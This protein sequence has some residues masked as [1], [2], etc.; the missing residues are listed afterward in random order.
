MAGSPKP[1]SRLPAALAGV[2]LALA[3]VGIGYLAL[4]DSKAPPPRPMVG[5]GGS[6]QMGPAPVRPDPPST[7]EIPVQFS[8]RIPT[9]PKPVRPV[10]DEGT[11]V[12]ARAVSPQRLRSVEDN[13]VERLGQVAEQRDP[14]A[15][16][17]LGLM[18]AKGTG[19]GRD[20]TEAV[21]WFRRAAE[22][23]NA[24]AQ[25]WLGFMY[26]TGRGVG[27]DD[28]EAVRWYRRAIKKGNA[29]AQDNLGRMYETGRGVG[30]DLVEAV[31]WY[32]MAA[33]QGYELAKKNLD[34]LRKSPRP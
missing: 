9:Q 13:R 4:Q 18:Y 1:H 14:A 10:P 15:E 26:Q 11:T 23:G 31:R 30:R 5:R 25:T 22:E 34:R 20:D 3:M 27:Q 7:S 33:D 12:E 24:D 29:N 6:G 19:V 16:H 21:R 32:Q 17:H 8:R 2:L 28:A